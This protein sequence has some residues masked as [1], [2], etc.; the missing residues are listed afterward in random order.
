MK[1]SSDSDDDLPPSP[2]NVQQVQGSGKDAWKSTSKEKWPSIPD[3]R[4]LGIAVP[5]SRDFWDVLSMNTNREILKLLWDFA[6]CPNDDL[7]VAAGNC[8]T[9]DNCWS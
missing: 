3:L 8:Y 7:R 5:K 1:E 2:N 4:S 9:T 6:N